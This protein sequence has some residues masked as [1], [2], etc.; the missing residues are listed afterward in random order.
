MGSFRLVA[1]TGIFTGTTRRAGC[2]DSAQ[3]TPFMRV[4]TYLD[5]TI[6]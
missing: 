2:G 1:V 4:R 5:M 3:I 6:P